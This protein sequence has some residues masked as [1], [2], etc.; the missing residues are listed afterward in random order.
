MNTKN[1]TKFLA[2]FIAVLILTP[3]ISAFAYS[4]VNSSTNNYKEI[5]YLEDNNMLPEFPDN[6]FDPDAKVTPVDFYTML[7]QYAGVDIAD[8]MEVDLPFT[9]ISDNEWYS[10]YIQTALDLK[11]LTPIDLN[12]V[13]QP[14]KKL[15]KREIISKLFDSLGIGTSKFFDKDLF[16]FTDLNSNGNF[17]PYAFKAYEIGIDT[18]GGFG[19]ASQV[20]KAELARYIYL[21]NKYSPSGIRS[22]KTTPNI[23]VNVTQ[24]TPIENSTFDIFMDVWETIHSQYY[25]QNEI[26]DTEMLYGAIEGIIETLDDHYTEFTEPQKTNTGDPLKKEYEGIGMSVELLDEAI[27]VV[28]PFKGSPAEKA[29]IKP[30]DIILKINNNS[31]Q[32]LNLSEAV[33]FIKGK[34]GTIVTLTIQRGTKIF[35]IQV[36]RGYIINKTVELKFLPKDNGYIAILNLYTFGEDTLKEFTLAAQQ[37]HNKQSVEKNIKGIILD[38]RSNPGGYLDIAIDL[39]GFFFDSNKIVTILENNKGKQTAYKSSYE[40]SDKEY[41][42]GM[43]LLS[44]FKTVILINK[45]SASA[46]EILAGSLQDYSKAK[47]IGEQTFGKG[48]VQEVSYYDDNSIFKL[49]ISKWLTPLSRDIN[50]KGL[51]PDRIVTNVGS[52]D[53]QLNTAIKEF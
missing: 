15:T 16:P 20:S 6:K 31:T 27:T 46:S 44:E 9:D 17:A 24:S 2:C 36:T 32:G 40:G 19:I 14:Y 29:G 13:F 50:K 30:N 7:I 22:T 28:S 23:T 3:S 35:D 21:I 25:Y 10:P 26:D 8:K 43:G 33:D 51:T 49:T 48:T 38:L 4:D 1:I 42:T 53:T 18:K 12:P 34:A 5:K 39:N 45:G 47:L 37:I 11:I 41:S 52:E